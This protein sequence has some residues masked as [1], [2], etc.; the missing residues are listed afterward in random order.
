MNKIK[1]IQALFLLSIISILMFHSAVPH[2]HHFH[3]NVKAESHVHVDHDHGHSHN[4]D[5]HNTSESKGFLDGLLDDLAHGIHSDEYLTSDTPS[6]GTL[7]HFD[8]SYFT[9]F[10]IEPI[11][12]SPQLE[13]NNLHRYTLYKQ[14]H[15]TNPFLQ[16][17]SLRAPPYLG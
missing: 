12:L 2:I 14:G 16:S 5:D 3:K 17:H 9:I 4:H 11:I 13:K 8:L 15:T 6:L 7:F 1:Q 10:Q